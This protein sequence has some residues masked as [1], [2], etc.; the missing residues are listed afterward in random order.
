MKLSN[1]KIFRLTSTLSRGYVCSLKSHLKQ[2]S[3]D[4]EHSIL[5][6]HR[7]H[8]WL[9]EAN[10][11]SWF[12]RPSHILT[13][14][15]QLSGKEGL[16]GDKVLTFSDG[17]LNMCYNCVDRH[18]MPHQASPAI[19]YARSPNEYST[20]TYLDLYNRVNALAHVLKT[21]Y[22]VKPNDTVLIYMPHIPEAIYAMLACARLGV[23]YS[24][25]QSTSDYKSLASELQHLSPK[26][27]ITTED[28]RPPIN[29]IQNLSQ[30]FKEASIS[31]IK[32][33]SLASET[34]KHVSKD[35]KFNSVLDIL[36]CSNYKPVSV[37]C[38]A[39]APTHPLS[40]NKTSGTEGLPRGVLRDTAGVAVY[41]Q[42][43]MRSTFDFD[44]RNVFY[45]SPGFS[46]TYGQ[47]YG[48]YGPLLLGGTTFLYDGE[49]KDMEIYW[50]LLAN[51]KINGFLTFPRFIDP[52]RKTDLEGK[53][54]QNY[55]LS[56][57][58]TFTLTGERCST[59]TF[60]WLK[61][62]I[63]GD[64]TVIDAYMQQE[65][66]YPIIYSK[67][68]NP[69]LGL[70]FDVILAQQQDLDIQTGTHMGQIL[71]SL[72]LPPGCAGTL[73]Q[74]VFKQEIAV[75]HQ[76]KFYRT[77]DSG[78]INE[79]G[80]VEVC[81]ED[82]IVAVGDYEFSSS[83]IEEQLGYHRF[84]KEISVVSGLFKKEDGQKS[85]APKKKMYVTGKGLVNKQ[86]NT[87][88]K[89]KMPVAFVVL[90]EDSQIS[91][92]LLHDEL[93]HM[94]KNDISPLL[95]LKKIVVVK[96]LPRNLNGM[97]MKNLLNEMVVNKAATVPKNVRN[98]E[99]IKEI[100][101]KLSK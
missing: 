98:K 37:D 31:S 6:V 11:L 15:R 71:V 61:N 75:Q 82:D 90:K 54:L 44:P 27:V 78:F 53:R 68:E 52:T 29:F 57:L 87:V 36:D 43:L 55:D 74:K 33:L 26:L 76:G 81:R 20:V 100:E 73:S 18:L 8:F 85:L 79:D 14:E 22:D 69:I 101:E 67:G 25:S 9:R 88:G 12:K 93:I 58:K 21:Y 10:S 19:I 49:Y 32:T 50:K 46:W 99:C 30:A 89:E 77:G 59:S 95:S 51:Y 13:I 39:L 41:L 86:E 38:A 64:V 83:I 65:T 35:L 42:T 66:G 7:E 28:I 24:I 72:P 4:Y 16:K 2:Q 84:I 23:V 91:H 34:S 45:C 5:D 62:S 96:E 17:E 48:V 40:L 1:P 92:E 56:A 47:N 63:S 3:K 80:R 94:I 70:G 60:N 97:V